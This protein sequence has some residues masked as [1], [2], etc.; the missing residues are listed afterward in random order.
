[1]TGKAGG[2]VRPSISS[3]SVWQTPQARTAMRISPSPA[4]G[5][6]SSA[7]TSG[8]GF[9]AKEETPL[10]IIAFMRQNPH[11]LIV[12]PR[13]EKVDAVVAD[14]V[15]NAVLLRQAAGP[16][17]GGKI[18]QGFWLADPGKGIAQDRLDDG[19][20]PQRDLS[21]GFHPVAQVLPEL[22]LEYGFPPHSLSALC[23]MTS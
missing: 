2:G 19:K 7:A 18:F 1:M 21:I 14:Q 20:R 12:I 22:R 4:T 8:A 23:L 3:S 13:L 6:G 15:N 5:I 17:A 9:S 11:P 16:H 10:R